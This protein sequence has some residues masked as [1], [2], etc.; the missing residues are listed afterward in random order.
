[1]GRAMSIF[2]GAL[3]E[4]GSDAVE[5]DG[6]RYFQCPAHDDRRASLTVRQGERGVL[7]KCYAGCETG[8][9]L[10]ALRLTAADLFDEE[11]KRE[12]G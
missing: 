8:E 10:A 4:H 3:R 9:V 7:V 6:S 1:M 2:L 11:E 5:M 12:R